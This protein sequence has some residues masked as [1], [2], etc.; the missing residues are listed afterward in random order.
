MTLASYAMVQLLTNR[1]QDKQ[2]QAGDIGVILEV[3]DHE[4]YEIEFSRAD[5]T[6][7]AWFA[8]RQDEVAAYPHREVI[9]QEISNS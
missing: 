1:Y 5:G 4:A 7:I 3:Y 9:I 8:I 2:V 6:T